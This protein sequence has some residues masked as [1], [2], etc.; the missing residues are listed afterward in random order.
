MIF[1]KLIQSIVFAFSLGFFSVTPMS[2]QSSE[3]S[4]KNPY[5][6]VNIQRA[7]I[8]DGY[9]K[10]FVNGVSKNVF[11][12]TNH[13]KAQLEVTHQNKKVLIDISY[14]INDSKVTGSK[15]TPEHPFNIVIGEYILSGSSNF[16]DR[17]VNNTSKKEIAKINSIGL[18][19]E[20]FDKVLKTQ[21]KNVHYI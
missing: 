11:F 10:K 5:A 9:T 2:S 12:G 19:K 7:G 1:K 8:S 20:D 6:I 14:S 13:Y 21:F 16:E 4:S 17:Y 15:E 18:S 3:T